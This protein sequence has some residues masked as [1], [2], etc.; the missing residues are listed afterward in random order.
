MLEANGATVDRETTVA[1]IP[2]AVVERAMSTVPHEYTLGARNPEY[3]LPLDGEHVYISSDGCGV[4]ARD[5]KTGEVR[6]SVKQ[7]LADCARVVQALDNVSATSAVV[8][9]Q[10]CP[11]ETRV[12]HEFDA[13]VRNSREAQH[14]RQ[15]QGGL[16][17]P[18]P[19]QDGRGHGRRQG[20]AEAPARC[21]PPSSA[22]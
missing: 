22:P 4:F 19:H 18:Q 16:G 2:A 6:S 21:S 5:P 8:S 17:G 10:D 9:A 12:L 3:D 20:G 1:K 11:P 7:D 15:H 14:R 13:C